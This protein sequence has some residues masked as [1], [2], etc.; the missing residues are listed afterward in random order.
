MQGMSV[1]VKSVA[2]LVVPFVAVFGLYDVVYGHV[3]PGG[4]F[5]G[6]VILAASGVLV[7]LA[8][9]EAYARRILSLEAVR[10]TGSAGALAFLAVALGGYAAGGFFVSFVGRGEV[11]GLVSGGTVAISS[12]AVGIEVA[13]VLFGVFVALAAFRRT[14]AGGKKEVDVLQ[15]DI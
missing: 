9:G 10:W 6:G 15:S 11:G 12:L 7:V 8:F 4:G 1:I 5:S 2:R 13:A 14:T 3:E